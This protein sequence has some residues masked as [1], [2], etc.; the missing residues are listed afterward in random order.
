MT[1]PSDAPVEASGLRPRVWAPADL[2][3]YEGPLL[4]DT[5]VWLWHVEGDAT[6][7]ASGTT[8]L[9]DRSGAH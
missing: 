7:V 6:H 2:A 8:A 3:A 5:H 1:R 9:L 4:L